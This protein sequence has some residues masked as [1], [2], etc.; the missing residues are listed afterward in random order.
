MRKIKILEIK[1]EIG[2]GTRGSCLG[3]DAIKTAALNSGDFFFHHHP[4]VEIPNKNE[5]LYL[6]VKY[7]CA[8]YIEGIS[9][10]YNNLS[11]K[12]AETLRQ[13][14]FP[15]I[16]SGDHASAGGV[17]AGIKMATPELRIG[18][19]WIDAHADLH[20]P[21]TSPSGHVHGMPLATAINEDNLSCKIRTPD[22]PAIDHWNQLKQTGG[23]A[24]KVSPK[25]I[26][27]IA[28]RDY[29]QEEMSLIKEKGIH[30]ISVEELREKK[31]L[32][33]V[34]QTFQRLDACD[35]IYLSFDVDSL[36]ASLSRGT[37]TPVK[38]GLWEEE[39]VQLI[40]SFLQ[41]P[42]VCGFEITEVNPTLDSE[43]KMAEMAFNILTKGAKI[44]EKRDS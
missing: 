7:P 11:K 2:A 26:V 9:D 29:E 31:P 32:S 4:E 27:I 13:K 10:I 35:L 5:L 3:I 16:L 40:L 23:I 38:N 41:N 22:A 30:T 12:V 21:Y 39:A 44:I 28:L 34:E 19:V 8:Q 25:D 6:P 14:F 15:V 1:S 42:K 20:T 24:P 37:G 43:N 18:V 33:I 36:D 17:I